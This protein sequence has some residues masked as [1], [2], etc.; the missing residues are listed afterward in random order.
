MKGPIVVADEVRDALA[1]GRPV[2]ALESTIISHGMPYPRNREVALAAQ[3]LVRKQ[4]CVP[5]TVAILEG[6]PCVGLTHEQIERLAASENIL[7]ISRRDFGYAVAM[8]RDG[9]TTVCATMM[10]AHA[11]GIAVFATGGIGGVHRDH[12]SDVSADLAELAR[13]PV[14]VVSAGAKAILDLDRTLELLETLGVPVIGL[15]TDEFPAFYSRSSGIPVPLR[16]ESPEDLA[17]IYRTHRS[18]GL[19]QGV[20]VALPIPAADEI[21]R[22]QVEE[23]IALALQELAARGLSGK[24]VTP[25][26]L[27]RIVELS[28]GRA[29]EAN[30]GLLRN[31]VTMACRIAREL[32]APG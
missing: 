25:F 29:L 6:R 19:E 30:I 21:P 31:N 10:L 15:G 22:S 32:Q 28:G 14:I 4:G 23:W 27:G 18:L 9:A 2:V 3:D 12:P 20:L 11:A 16:A 26:L 24:E 13:T 7:K 17:R 5:A 8:G 1:E